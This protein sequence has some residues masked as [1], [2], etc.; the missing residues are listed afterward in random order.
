[1]EALSASLYRLLLVMML[2]VAGV[3]FEEQRWTLWIVACCVLAANLIWAV[4]VSWGSASE[5]RRVEAH[6]ARYPDA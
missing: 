3:F 5:R 6:K 1:M 4:A 2:G